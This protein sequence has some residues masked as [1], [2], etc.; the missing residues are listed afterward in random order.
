MASRIAVPRHG[1]SWLG[2]IRHNLPKSLYRAS[3]PI[4]IGE[5]VS[6]RRGHRRQ[7]VFLQRTTFKMRSFLGRTS[8]SMKGA[9]NE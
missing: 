8:P 1:V 6:H 2:P 5:W 9:F 4:G 7:I 3:N